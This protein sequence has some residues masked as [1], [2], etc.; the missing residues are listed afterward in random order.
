MGGCCCCWSSQAWNMKLVYICDKKYRMIFRNIPM[1]D[2]RGP[3]T[4]VA[5][6]RFLQVRSR[7]CSGRMRRCSSCHHP[8]RSH[9]CHNRRWWHFSFGSRSGRSASAPRTGTGRKAG[10]RRRPQ[11]EVSRAGGAASRCAGPAA[12]GWA[13]CRTACRIGSCSCFAR[14]LSKRSLRC[15][16][17]GARR[18]EVGRR[19]RRAALVS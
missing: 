18:G 15:E 14:A 4:E 10:G 6:H 5:L 3:W 8:Y 1:A 13:G 2:Q 17:A 9:H 16:V 12:S 7:C 11:T 19:G